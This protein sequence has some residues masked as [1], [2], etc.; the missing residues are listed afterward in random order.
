MRTTIKKLITI[1]M[2]VVSC[3]PVYSQLSLSEKDIF[4]L[5]GD[6]KV[7][8]LTRVYNPSF[9]QEYFEGEADG[10]I[11]DCMYI[12]IFDEEGR[13]ISV[14]EYDVKESNKL[15]SDFNINY[16]GDNAIVNG[17]VNEDLPFKAHY[18]RK[19]DR[20]EI[21]RDKSYI[22]YEGEYEI[23]HP[24]YAREGKEYAKGEIYRLYV[25][26]SDGN[27]PEVWF[28][29]SVPPFISYGCDSYIEHATFKEGINVAATLS[30]EFP[31]GGDSY[32]I[33]DCDIQV[34]S[35]DE[36]G[37]W[38]ERVAYQKGQPVFMEVRRL[39]YYAP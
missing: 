11:N 26:D 38:T 1:T 6:V 21:E 3:H 8:G 16:S 31:Y 37:N 34:T 22:Q 32:F 9:L 27:M 29:S 36:L 33:G 23:I 18:S 19:I 17:T 5:K 30:C 25:F 7:M 24:D 4:S 12:V 35:T 39:S 13:P 10:I 28:E 15:L 2:A 14:Q 20:S